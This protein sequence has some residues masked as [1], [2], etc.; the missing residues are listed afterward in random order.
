MVA[1]E[2][3]VALGVILA[4]GIPGVMSAIGVSMTGVAAAGLI[5]EEPKKFSRAFILE[6]LPGTQGFYGFIAGMLIMIGTGLLGGG[7]V[8]FEAGIGLAALVASIPAIIQGF[9]SY[10][11][12]LVATSGV[13]AIAKKEETFGS[14]VLLAVMVETYAILGFLST[15]LLLIG[16]GIFG[17]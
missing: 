5:S 9:T 14:C 15:F 2:I 1:E 3:L 11:Q 4:V 8:S 17:A 12:G 10:Y 7:E 13:S 6:I 16:L